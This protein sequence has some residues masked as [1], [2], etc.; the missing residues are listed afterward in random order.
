[1]ISEVKLKAAAQRARGS[2][3]NRNLFAF[4]GYFVAIV[5]QVGCVQLQVKAAGFS[6][7]HVE[8][9]A[10][11]GRNMLVQPGPIFHDS[12]AAIAQ[13]GPDPGTSPAIAIEKIGGAGMCLI[14]S[15]LN[16]LPRIQRLV[17]GKAAGHRTIKER[18]SKRVLHSGA[19]AQPYQAAHIQDDIS[20]AGAR[21]MEVNG[22]K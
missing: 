14:K 8:T 17:T 4:L 20:S 16:T 13:S 15:R 5:S 6:L 10:H 18:A 19:Y 21:C 12:S 7:P 11:I 2:K 9:C 1:M 3:L 22:K